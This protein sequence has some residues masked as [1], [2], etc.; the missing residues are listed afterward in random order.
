MTGC[1]RE[2]ARRRAA[3]A[4]VRTVG[5]AVV[6]ALLA[7]ATLSSVAGV[8]SGSAS[9]A[10]KPT[11]A[12][13]FAGRVLDEAILPPGVRVTTSAGSA[14]LEA[15]FETIDP[16]AAIDFHRYYFVDESPQAV[17]TYLEAHVPS[18]S[19]LVVEG[20]ITDTPDGDL[21]G[22]VY[23]IPV[24]GPHEVEAELDYL[25]GTVAGGAV[26]RVDAETVWEPDRPRTER[27]PTHG[28]VEVTGFSRSSAMRGSSGPVTFVVPAAR[29]RSV[30]GVLNALPLGPKGIC[31]EDALLF[32]I[33][34]RPSKEAPPSFEAEG[35]Q[36]PPEVEV[37][38]HGRPMP[39]LYDANCALLRAVVKVLLAHEAEATREA[40]VGCDPPPAAT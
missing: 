26:I 40:A 32:E 15:P 12:E 10:A 3:V 14:P 24:S 27:A 8:T 20:S 25:S 34:V 30:L 36:C 39:A 11:P 16:E 18:R 4:R 37:T 35:W 23:S 22:I 1:D 29:A 5:V 7:A 17:E 31:M 38:G 33:T 21:P 13:A 28:V 19:R 6:V 9:G 2:H